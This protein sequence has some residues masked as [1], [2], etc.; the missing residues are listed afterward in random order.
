MTSK[1]LEGL[2]I[3]DQGDWVDLRIAEGITMKQGELKAVSLGIR[4]LLPKGF[5]AL[6][7]PRSSTGKRYKVLQYNS[8][9]LIDNSYNGPKDIW[10]MLLYAV[11]DTNIKCGE[12][13]AQF[14]IQPKMNSGVWVKLKWLFTGKVRFERCDLPENMRNRGGLGSTNKRN[15]EDRV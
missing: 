4:M 12:R 13:I 7:I 6:V 11:G 2:T 9:G 1:D 3:L 5:E 15:T 10:H 14:R 8:M